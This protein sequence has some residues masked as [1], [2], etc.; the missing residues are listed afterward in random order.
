MAHA[1]VAIED[2]RFYTE[3]GDRLPR[4]RARASSPTSSAPAAARRAPRRSPSSSSS[5]RC[6]RSRTTAR[7]SRSSR[8]RRSPSSSRTCGRKQT[9]PR[10]L[11][12]HRLLRQRRLRRRGGGAGVLRQRPRLDPLRLRPAAEHQ[13][14]GEPVR[15]E[16]DRRRG[17]AARRR[18][19]TRRRASTASRTPGA[20][21][22][23]AQPRAQGHVRAGL[24]DRARVP[25]AA[26]RRRC[27]R[28]ST[29]SR[30][31][32]EDT[33]PERRLL[34]QLGRERSCVD[35]LDS[36]C[37]NAIYTG[38]YQHPHDARQPTCRSDAQT[39]S[40]R[41][42]CRRD[43]RARRRRSSRSTTRPARSGRW[44]AATTSTRTPSTSR[45]QAERQP[46]SAWK[47][48]D[49]AAALES[50]LQAEHDGLSAP[51]RVP[52]TGE[53]A[54]RRRSRP[55]R[56]GRLLQREDPAVAGARRLRQ[57]RLRAPR[58][59]Q[60]VGR[61]RTIAADRPRSS[62]SRRRSRSTRRW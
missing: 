17:G 59:R 18:S 39:R 42:S 1:I 47:V 57:Q 54:V 37:K 33:D 31:S 12:Q 14:P 53:P 50:G 58:P 15:D 24:P 46:G 26:C 38:G 61:H 45:P 21:A 52:T 4:H 19:S 36:G 40:R 28:R 32:E 30:P 3:P 55:Q 9:D 49:L 7:S 43:R 2:K 44:S 5:T 51:V 34:R 25:Q 60:H 29:C 11:P 62:A 56:R 48:F 23:P 8:R 27:R 6:R 10:R 22:R 20:C 41:T 16:P 35:D 13:R